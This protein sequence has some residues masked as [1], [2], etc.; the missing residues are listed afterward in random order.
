MKRFKTKI[1]LDE[2]HPYKNNTNKNKSLLR[3][4]N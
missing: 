1:T 4:K 2:M 3:L